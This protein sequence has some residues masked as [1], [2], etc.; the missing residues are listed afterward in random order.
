VERALAAL[1]EERKIKQQ[2][3]GAKTSI[4]KAYDLV[5]GMAERVRAHLEEIDVLVRPAGEGPAAPPPVDDS[6]LAL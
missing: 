5:E 2:L 4:G 1:A 6:Q 3:T